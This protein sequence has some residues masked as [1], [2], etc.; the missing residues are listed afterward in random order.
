MLLPAAPLQDVSEKYKLSRKNQRNDE[1]QSQSLLF[2]NKKLRCNDQALVPSAA[3]SSDAAIVP[4]QAASANAPFALQWKGRVKSQDLVAAQN[5]KR[6]HLTDAAALGAAV[7]RN[8]C[9]CPASHFGAMALADV[10]CQALLRAEIRLGATRIA[11]MRN[12]ISS[13][14]AIARP[15]S[16]SSTTPAIA[17]HAWS[18][19]Y[20]DLAAR[21]VCTCDC[22]VV[23]ICLF[24]CS[25]F[26]ENTRGSSRVMGDYLDVLVC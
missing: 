7:R 5:K 6:W 19:S 9:N 4:A 22:V 25:R 23:C 24:S 18:C 10:S 21:V 11:S 12:F 3:S 2:Q 26:L 15:L 16:S 14:E 17:V 8:L 20:G 1:K 13:M